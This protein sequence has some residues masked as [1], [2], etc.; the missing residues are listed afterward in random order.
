MLN[1]GNFDEKLDL[2]IFKTSSFKTLKITPAMT[3]LDQSPINQQ[4]YM[5]QLILPILM[6]LIK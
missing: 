3:K 4:V 1:E 6:I 5:Q 2:E